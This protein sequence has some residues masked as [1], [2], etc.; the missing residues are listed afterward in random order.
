MISPMISTYAIS[1]RYLAIPPLLWLT[2]KTTLVQPP[3]P[4]Y[5][6]VPESMRPVLQ[7]STS[8]VL[9]PSAS[10]IKCEKTTGSVHFVGRIG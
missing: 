4:Y 10:N 2:T 9:H 8:P 5:N 1:L 7:P 3:A 6:P